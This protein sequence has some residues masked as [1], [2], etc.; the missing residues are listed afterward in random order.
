MDQPNQSPITDHQSLSLSPLGYP[1]NLFGPNQDYE[2]VNETISSIVLQEKHPTPWWIG[3][4]I[5]FG[6]FEASFARTSESVPRT[7]AGLS[8]PM[9]PIRFKALSFAVRR[10]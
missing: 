5:A 9:I 2:T 3:F 6:N 4:V 7:C 1:T 8:W 10:Q